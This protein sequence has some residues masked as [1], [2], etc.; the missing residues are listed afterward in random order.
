MNIEEIEKIY[1]RIQAAKSKA[2]RT[3]K[4]YFTAVSKTRT[5]DEMKEAEKISW[6]DYF[7]ENRVQEAES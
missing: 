4:I 2:N 3:D 5:V 6:I 7:G 1:E